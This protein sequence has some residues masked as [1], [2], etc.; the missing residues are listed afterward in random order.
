MATPLAPA[1]ALA[2]A[3][4]QNLS[5][6]ECEKVVVEVLENAGCRGQ[7]YSVFTWVVCLVAIATC[8]K[9]YFLVKT[10]LAVIFVT[11]HSLLILSTS[12][13]V[14]QREPDSRA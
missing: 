13:Q 5:Q 4:C 10:A 1:L 7:A 11:A 8:L 3:S 2:P 6:A 12:P 14:F 9:L